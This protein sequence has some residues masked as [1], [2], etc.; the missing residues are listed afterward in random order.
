M[1]AESV[2]G[3]LQRAT[4]ISGRNGAA[5]AV[6][7][8]LVATMGLP[9]ASADTTRAADGGVSA[10]VAPAR[11][12]PADLATG[13]VSASKSALVRF[14]HP[15]FVVALTDGHRAQSGHETA[16]A[17][18]DIARTSRSM[19]RAVYKQ[20]QAK[21]TPKSTPKPT[22]QPKAKPQPLPR[23][24]PS[25]VSGA[26]CS[27]S[28]SIESHLTSNARSVYRA[29]CAAFGHTV[30][31][32]GG[33]RPGDPGDHGS[34]RAVDIMV[35]GQ[36]GLEIARYVQA[37]AR[38]LHVKYVIY[39]QRIWLAGHPGQWRLMEDR[40]SRTQNHYDHVHVSVS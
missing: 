5:L 14:E 40:G 29:V 17:A 16:H 28:S 13:Q 23:R 30:S 18:A 27:I 6:T 32:F 36:P 12:L 19:A 22:T 38:E 21:S 20:Q 7:S 2:T 24:A 4:A 8:G 39:Q 34:G 3:G 35:S 1:L 11:D 15:A 10:A 31:A 26:P 25:G 37:H 33:Y 9:A